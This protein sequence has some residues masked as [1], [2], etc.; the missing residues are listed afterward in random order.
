MSHTPEQFC[1]LDGD[2]ERDV[3]TWCRVWEDTRA[4]RPHDHPGFLQMMRSAGCFP[5][6]VAYEHPSGARVLYPFYWRSLDDLPFSSGRNAPSI[7]IVSPYGYGG[8]LYEG[9]PEDRAAVS[10]AFEAMFSDELHVRG[11]V[12]EFVR[13]DLCD[14]RLAIRSQGQ[15]LAQQPNVVVRLDRNPDQVWREYLPKV[16]K[17]VNRARQQG[18]RVV[19]DPGGTYLDDFL[20]VYHDTMERT[21]AAASFFIDKAR[22]ELLGGTLGASGGLTYVH[23]F[24][25]EQ[26]VSTELL[27]LS[28]DTVYSFL[29]GTLP[30]FFEMRPN[31]LLIDLLGGALP[32]GRPL[33]QPLGAR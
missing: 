23:V 16:R 20:S 9:A 30:D 25:G 15:R 8:P 22:F 18:L 27:L 17:N 32:P 26:I 29:G 31:D 6:A 13:E 3:A 12:S 24:A 1:W 14:D 21:G 11:A 10:E 28:P 19:F 5:A 2:N 4:R 7:H 33:G